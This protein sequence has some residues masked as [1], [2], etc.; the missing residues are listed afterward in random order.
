MTVLGFANLVVN[1]SQLF[2]A[3]TSIA[4]LYEHPIF[5]LNPTIHIE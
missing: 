4:H 1:L 3:S 5:Q 2:P